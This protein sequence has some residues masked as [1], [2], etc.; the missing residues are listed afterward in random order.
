[1]RK[2]S[3]GFTYL[4]QKIPKISEA[5]LE[6]G[7]FVDRQITMY[8]DCSKKLY[9]TKRRAWKVFLKTSAETFSA[10]RK[11]KITVKFCSS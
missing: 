4:R 2:E 11:R 5:E 10:L 6:E 1:M 9:S 8:Q 3:E 7:D